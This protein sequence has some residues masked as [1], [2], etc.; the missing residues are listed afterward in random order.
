M[1]YKTFGARHIDPGPGLTLLAL[2]S[3]SSISFLVLA[4][5]EYAMENVRIGV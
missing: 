1:G 2:T 5:F 4:L 3:P